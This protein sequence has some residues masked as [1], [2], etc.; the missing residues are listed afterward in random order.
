MVRPNSVLLSATVAERYGLAPG[1]SLQARSGGERFTLDI[2][3]LLEPNDDLSRRAL[4]SLLI[5]D[6]AT[7]QEVLGKIGKIDRIDLIVA[8]GGEGAVDL[9]RIEAILPPGARIVPA[10]ARQGAVSQMT[11]AFHPI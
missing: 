11:A 3:G 8:E 4:D 2:V 6:I 9:A 5:A 10:A 1:D 7:G